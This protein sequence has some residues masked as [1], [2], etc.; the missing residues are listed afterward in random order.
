[1]TY[2]LL[3]VRWL[4]NRYHGKLR[5]DGPAEW[6]PSPYR[7][8]QALVA[9]L[10]RH[11]ELC[12]RAE[13]SLVWL[14]GL[15][16]PIILTPPSQQGAISLRYVPNNDADRK[17]NRQ[18]RLTEK[19]VCPTLMLS[20]P[21]VHFLWPIGSATRSISD[22]V[23]EVARRLTCLGWGIDLAYCE[24]RL[25]DR[26][27][28]NSLAG[29]RWHAREGIFRHG[30]M[31]R[32]PISE[33]EDGQGSL[34]DLRACHESATRRIRHG[35]PLNTV[36][37]P[38]CFR[39]V[40]YESREN[41]VAPPSA[42]FELQKDDGSFFPYDQRKLI[43]IAGMVRHAA[44][45]AMKIAP[46]PGWSKDQSD[47]WVRTY[48]AGHADEGVTQHRQF[49]YLPLP[50]I[51]HGHADVLVRRV[52]ITAPPG[53]AR[54]LDHLALRLS[55]QRLEPTSRTKLEQPPTLVRAASD[56]M[57]RHY[58]RP[59]NTWAT[60]TPVILPGHDDHKPGKTRRLIEKALAQSGIEQPCEF[61][62]S[63]FSCFPKMLSAHKYDRE[64]RPTGHIRPPLL[65]EQNGR[66][67]EA[68][69]QG[70]R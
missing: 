46:P 40:F 31:L 48:V 24:G 35:H 14:Q 45:E 8:F 44:I 65:A 21:E 15:G 47:D 13:E 27:E 66:P 69:I 2:L 28:A 19:R 3:T 22:T 59:S 67:L 30:R 12:G 7:L 37:K 20:T 38:T 34:H 42:V 4:D 33:G 50:S 26:R 25:I 10:A 62:W 54:F 17:L 1:M 23:C 58:T 53:D 51:G 36:Q 39:E 61:E 29:V 55:G 60:I 63:A 68:E 70:R 16:P 18:D 56:K 9:G 64:K 41:P 43:H 11:D 52:M 57:E 32:V 49:S 5:K 6:P